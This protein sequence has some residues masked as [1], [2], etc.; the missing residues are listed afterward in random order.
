MSS[1]LISMLPICR[2]G[3]PWPGRML[4]EVVR[5]GKSDDSDLAVDLE[6][7]SQLFWE[8]ALMFI[9]QG[10][11]FN[12]DGVRRPC[13]YECSKYEIDYLIACITVRTGLASQE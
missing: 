4:R 6:I 10:S 2:H 13:N 12:V 7:K 5:V 1:A 3:V 11:S 8:R 9:R